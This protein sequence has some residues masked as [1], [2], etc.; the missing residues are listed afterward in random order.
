MMTEII[1]EARERMAT[2]IHLERGGAVWM[3]HHGKLIR[4]RACTTS[5][6]D[7][8]NQQLKAAN[9]KKN[10]V[11]GKGTFCVSIAACGRIRVHTYAAKG[12]P[13]LALR[14]LPETIPSLRQLGL[15]CHVSELTTCA[16]GLIV[17]SGA[18]GSGK[19]TTLAALLADINQERPLHIMTFEDPIEYVIPSAQALVHQCELGEDMPDYLSGIRSA[20]RADPDII[21][22][23]EMRDKETVQAAMT[24]AET[25]HL[26]LTTL[27]ASSASETI[28]RLL[29]LFSLPEQEQI[30]RQLASLL[31]VVLFQKLLP[32]I[33]DTTLQ[34]A[35]EL[36]I[37]TPAV[38]NQIRDNALH[39][40]HSTMETGRNQ[41][42]MVL[43]DHLAQLFKRHLIS[44]EIAFQAAT[45]SMRLRRYLGETIDSEKQTK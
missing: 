40:L 19:S 7:D 33:T 32:N 28:Y 21:M 38:A 4:Q 44:R 1:L 37:N 2:D 3:R 11:Q 5:E 22:L 30:R 15:P 34:L 8:L 25:G 35:C 36:L 10:K 16:H 41:G 26:V 9:G 39:Q 14:L 20:L 27:H 6:F 43:E 29:D 45:D 24:L 42:M 23:G 18:T 13:C 31:Q 12:V 17:V